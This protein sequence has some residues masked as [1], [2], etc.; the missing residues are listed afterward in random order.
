MYG[1]EAHPPSALHPSPPAGPGTICS[2]SRAPPERPEDE[3]EE[4]PLSTSVTASVDTGKT[5]SHST[6]HVWSSDVSFAARSL[7]RAARTMAV[8]IPVS[9]PSTN[10]RRSPAGSFRAMASS[11]RSTTKSRMFFVDPTT[12]MSRSLLARIADLNISP[13]TS[14][15]AVMYASP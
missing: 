13:G 9:V 14:K 4:A 10:D 5:I 15:C 6:R 8:T 12:P 3:A 1:H 7:S 2:P 11:T